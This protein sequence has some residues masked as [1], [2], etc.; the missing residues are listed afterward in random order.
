MFIWDSEMFIVQLSKIWRKLCLNLCWFHCDICIWY[1]LDHTGTLRYIVLSIKIYATGS[2]DD[3]PQQTSMCHRSNTA[4]RVSGIW[5]VV[6]SAV[7][8]W[9]MLAPWPEW[10]ISVT[11]VC[12]REALSC[13]CSRYVSLQ[14]NYKAESFLSSFS[15]RLHHKA[16]QY[17]VFKHLLFLFYTHCI[18]TQHNILLY[19][20]FYFSCFIHIYC[21]YEWHLSSVHR[22]TAKWS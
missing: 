19:I 22:I 3:S 8:S 13:D 7:P 12:Y 15:L 16:T 17:L 21:W 14:W 9:D 10:N 4:Q 1:Q 5:Y 6:C 2:V 18:G 11:L 20:Y